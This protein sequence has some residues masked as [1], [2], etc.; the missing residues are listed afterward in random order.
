MFLRRV[1]ANA[2]LFLPFLFVLVL[3]IGWA[4]P[5]YQP[6]YLA[7]LLIWPL[8]WA[9]FDYCPLTKWELMIRKVDDPTIDTNTEIIRYNVKKYFGIWLPLSTIYACGLAVFFTLLYLSVFE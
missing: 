9:L 1:A 2:V 4:S 8:C 7:L 5:A 3:L 6:A